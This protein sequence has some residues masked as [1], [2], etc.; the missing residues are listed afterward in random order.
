MKTPFTYYWSRHKGFL[1]AMT[2]VIIACAITGFYTIQA[3]FAIPVFI[4]VL[5][6][7]TS[8][9]NPEW[10]VAKKEFYAMRGCIICLKRKPD[11]TGFVCDK[12]R[13][14]TDFNNGGDQMLGN[15]S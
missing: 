10:E 7:R 2:I 15:L 12:C 1:I 9:F 3:W 4:L 13:N 8:R 14:S 11:I 6:S 5:F